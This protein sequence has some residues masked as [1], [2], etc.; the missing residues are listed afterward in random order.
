MSFTP[1][2]Y[3]TWSFSR[4]Y[5]D[6]IS[7]HGWVFQ[8][9]WKNSLE[10]GFVITSYNAYQQSSGSDGIIRTTFFNGTKS[11]VSCNCSE[12]KLPF[13]VRVE[14][15]F[16]RTES[17]KDKEGEVISGSFDFEIGQ[18]LNPPIIEDGH[19]IYEYAVGRADN[20]SPSLSGTNFR[21]GVG[22]LYGN[23]QAIKKRLGRS[24]QEDRYTEN[25]ENSYPLNYLVGASLC[26]DWEGELCEDVGAKLQPGS[27]YGTG[28]MPYCITESNYEFEQKNGYFLAQV[29]RDIDS[30]N[31]QCGGFINGSQQ[32]KSLCRELVPNTI[33][34]YQWL[35]SFPKDKKIK[36]KL[37]TN[38]E[39]KNYATDQ[40]TGASMFTTV[41]VQYED[42]KILIPPPFEYRQ[43]ADLLEG[44]LHYC[45]NCCDCCNIGESV[46]NVLSPGWDE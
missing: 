43:G 24:T 13:T 29:V 33:T 42:Q 3:R 20:I 31:Y 19:R 46:L 32:Y 17:C 12:D 7:P 1:C 8:G 26:K 16:E 40:L 34:N 36:P 44:T 11:T 37:I 22:I 27:A 41:Y 9:K 15:G 14:N 39:P 18:R 23:I 35:K 38:G 2:R 25:R 30:I 45:E 5:G 10:T 21:G 28:W 6:W 4:G